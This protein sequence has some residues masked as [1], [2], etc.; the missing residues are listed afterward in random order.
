MG[1]A[2]ISLIAMV[3]AEQVYLVKTRR[4]VDFIVLR[5]KAMLLTSSIYLLCRVHTVARC[6]RP[7]SS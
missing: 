3:F 7:F 5:L 4:L 6:L 2:T 1:Q